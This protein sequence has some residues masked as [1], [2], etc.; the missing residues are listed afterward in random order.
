[1]SD[2]DHIL[3]IGGGLVGLSA[4]Y[5]LCKGKKRVTLIA[6]VTGKEDP[7]TTAL[8]DGTVKY[9]DS[10]G[11]WEEIGS[12]AHPLKTMRLV[13]AT[14]RLI[15]FQQVDF[16]SAE[17]GIDAFGYN[18]RNSQ[19]A[20]VLEQRLGAIDG[21]TRCDGSLETLSITSTHKIVASVTLASGNPE[22]IEADFIVGADGRNSKVRNYFDYGTKEWSY[23]QSAIVL[24]FEHELDSRFVS[25]EFHTETGPF[26]VVPQEPK[27]AGLVWLENPEQVETVKSLDPTALNLLLEEKMQSFLGKVSVLNNLHSFPMSGLTANRFGD[28]HHALVGEAA[29][30][31]PPIGAQGFNLGARDVEEL[32]GVLTQTDLSENPGHQ[33]HVAR[34][35]DITTRSMGVDM[36]N[37]SLLSD[38]LPIQIARAAGI[39]AL[40]NMS[41][42]RTQAMKLGIAP[43]RF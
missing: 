29:H 2:N 16:Q 23:P 28:P 36:L 3:V 7:R 17:I 40:D 42:L 38:F 12:F 14:K 1:M 41:P 11:L 5:A 20:E 43:I 22:A 25:T 24:D 8:L 6:P 9:L 15:R 33:Y 13:D 26:T 4:A 18:V 37:R 32:V 19:F 35:A 34:T 27:R 30:V 31:F 39:F 10:L 21:F